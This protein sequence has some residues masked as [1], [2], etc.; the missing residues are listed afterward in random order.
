MFTTGPTKYQS[1]IIIAFRGHGGNDDEGI[2]DTAGWLNDVSNDN[3]LA[4][5]IADI[6]EGTWC[7][8]PKC[9]GFSPESVNELANKVSSLQISS[10]SRIYLLGHGDINSTRLVRWSATAVAALLAKAGIP[11]GALLSV[12]GCR[13]AGDQESL[14]GFF[15][16]QDVRSFAARLHFKLGKNHGIWV[17]LRARSAKVYVNAIGTKFTTNPQT[18]EADW[19]KKNVTGEHHRAGSKYEWTWQGMPPA[20]IQWCSPV[21]YTAKGTD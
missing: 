4:S 20:C 2:S 8:S 6:Y 10:K 13:S 5:D 19:G 11:S 9:P 12:L 7:P 18:I 3:Q 21:V 14:E 1:Q 15:S 16:R 17:T